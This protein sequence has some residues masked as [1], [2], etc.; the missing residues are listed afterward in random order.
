MIQNQ[1][2]N[3]CPWKISQSFLKLN[4]IK[5]IEKKKKCL[6]LSHLQVSNW[7]F[8]FAPQP[9]IKIEIDKAFENIWSC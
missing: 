9:N 3:F 8:N 5:L 4:W 7:G 6:I 1:N 2:L